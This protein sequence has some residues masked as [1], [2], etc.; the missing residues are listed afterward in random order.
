MKDKFQMEKKSIVQMYVTSDDILTLSKNLLSS[1]WM[2]KDDKTF[3]KERQ[4]YTIKISY[5]HFPLIE[6]IADPKNEMFDINDWKF[7]KDLKELKHLGKR[8]N[9]RIYFNDKNSDEIKYLL[10]TM[11]ENNYNIVFSK[12]FLVLKQEKYKVNVFKISATSNLKLKKDGWY[13]GDRKIF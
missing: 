5:A 4:N 1:N 7:R 8:P 9:Y 2:K 3:L 6:V 10:Y 13:S 12:N 11:Y